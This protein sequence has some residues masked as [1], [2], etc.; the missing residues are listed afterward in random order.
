MIDVCFSESTR[1]NLNAFL[2]RKNYRGLIS[3][4]PSQD[5]REMIS[6]PADRIISIW[7]YLDEYKIN[8]KDFKEGRIELLSHFYERKCNA[9][10]RYNIIQND[11]NHIIDEAEKGNTIRIW[12][13]D[14][15]FSLCGLYYIA[16]RI[17]NTKAKVIIVNMPENEKYHSWAEIGPLDINYL[18]SSVHIAKKDEMQNYANEWKRL[19]S[20]N[21]EL[22]VVENKTVISVEKNYYDNIILDSATDEPIR[23]AKLLGT[24][25]ANI[26]ETGN[27]AFDGFICDRI[28]DMI[29]NNMFEIVGYYES[30]L[31]YEIYPNYILKKQDKK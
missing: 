12:C 13:S 26:G 23:F 21:S 30:N 16:S 7:Y 10:R 14:I 8:E 29:N 6:V 15:G 2:N 17:I 24:S 25:L 20:D 3:E 27:R 5:V 19:C 11:I 28:Q 22:R 31:Q 1:G 18:L 9:Q 4:E